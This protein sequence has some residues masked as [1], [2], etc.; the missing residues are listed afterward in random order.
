MFHQH[1]PSYRVVWFFAVLGLAGCST[2]SLDMSEERIDPAG[3]DGGVV[4]GSLLVQAEQEPSGSWFSRMFGR[5]AAGFTY[6]FEIVRAGTAD[7]THTSAYADRYELDAK[8]KEEQLFVARLPVG[9]CLFKSFRHE[10]LSAMGGELEVTFSV[11]PDTTQYIGR[12]VLDVPQR[13][14][15]GSPFTYRIENGRDATLAA[16]RK[17]HPDLGADVVNA[18]MQAK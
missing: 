8:P 6:D 1:I 12:L 4:I 16:V 14:T 18:P 5:R 3:P 9:S 17:R 11:A 7:Q 13:V 15:L 2:P 10:G